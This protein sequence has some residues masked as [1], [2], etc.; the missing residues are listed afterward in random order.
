MF[1]LESFVPVEFKYQVDPDKMGIKLKVVNHESLGAVSYTY[2]PED[3][4]PLYLDEMAKYVMRKPSRFHALSGDVV[5]EDT[6]AKLR[7][8]VAERK[9]E[10]AEELGEKPDTPTVMPHKKGLFKSLFKK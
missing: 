8:Q 6:L 5:P 7:Q 9:V 2:H 1:A 10:R 4:N 3:I